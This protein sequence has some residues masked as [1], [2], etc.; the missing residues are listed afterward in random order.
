MREGAWKRGKKQERKMRDGLRG[1]I[2]LRVL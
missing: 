1:T 2:T